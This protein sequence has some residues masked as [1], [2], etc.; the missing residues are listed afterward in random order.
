MEIIPKPPEEISPLKRL[1]FFFLFLISIFLFS[2]YFYLKNLSARLS[3]KTQ[4]LEKE[5]EE[6]NLKKVKEKEESLISIQKRIEMSEKLL[7]EHVF[8]SKIFPIIEGT[9][10]KSAKVK[11]FSFSYPGK[12]EVFLQFGTFEDLEKQY[13][14]F[15]QNQKI[16]NLQILE[17]KLTEEG[18]VG[19]KISFSIQPDVLK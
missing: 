13:S 12:V 3:L 8:P 11:S 18:E 16:E 6:I 7:S 19:A 14:A 2:F 4:Q 17:L 1:F 5:I 9:I 15:Q 10:L